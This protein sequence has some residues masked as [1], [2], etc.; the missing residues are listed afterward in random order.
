MC[1]VIMFQ[2]VSQIILDLSWQLDYWQHETSV[3]VTRTSLVFA[4]AAA[5]PNTKH[6]PAMSPGEKSSS[7]NPKWI[8]FDILPKGRVADDPNHPYQKTIGT[9]KFLMGGILQNIKKDIILFEGSP[10][11]RN[12][13]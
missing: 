11:D 1:V 2:M 10:K 3:C 5:N 9:S 7:P 12:T 6:L 13:N 8:C 4:S